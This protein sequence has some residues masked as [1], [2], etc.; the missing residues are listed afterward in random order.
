VGCAVYLKDMKDFAAMNAVYASFFPK[1][2][3]VRVAVQIAALAG[4]SSVEIQCSASLPGVA[5]KEVVVPTWPD[6]TTKFP[7]STAI[8]SGDFVFA[9]GFPGFDMRLGR[10]VPGGISA[11][12]RQALS[13]VR[14]AVEA[15][16][17]D[18]SSVVGCAV[19]MTDVKDFAAMNKAYAASFPHPPPSRVAFQVASLAGGAVVEIQCTAALPSAGRKQVVVPG[20]PDL[21]QKVPLSSGIAAGRMLFA[22]GLTGMDMQTLK[23]V[24]GGVQAET[25]QALQNLQEVVHAAGT[26]MSEVLSCAVYLADMRDFAAM[27]EVYAGF[28]PKPAPARVATQ[29][30]SLL[31]GSAVEIQCSAALP[32]PEN[33]VLVV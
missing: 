13:N 24:K 28:F 31:G 19:Y 11:E 4:N 32:K 6:L 33:D 15:A 22:S 23:P 26:T 3:P 17:S 10:L 21:S 27:N 14:E 1:P 30:A 8:V 7:F 2:R 25:K 18:M 20:W 16:G 9:S 29:V 5:R 12:T